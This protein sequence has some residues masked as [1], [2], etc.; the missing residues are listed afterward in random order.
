MG[1]CSQ[2]CCWCKDDRLSSDCD[3]FIEVEPGRILEVA[4]KL[5]Q[6]E[7]V[8]YVACSIGERDVSVQIVAQDNRVLYDF[9][10]QTIG[11][12]PGVGSPGLRSFL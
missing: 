12:L 7:N 4:N 2:R 10:A 9:V 11:S 5:A 6:Y 3:V 1:I 8:T